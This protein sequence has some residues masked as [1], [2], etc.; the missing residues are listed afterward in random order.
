MDDDHLYYNEGRV[1][2]STVRSPP[3]LDADGFM[4]PVNQPATRSQTPTNHGDEFESLQPLSPQQTEPI[5]DSAN[6]PIAFDVDGYV[7]VND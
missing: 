2:V 7:I 3:S 1:T 4:I 6:Q 5:Y